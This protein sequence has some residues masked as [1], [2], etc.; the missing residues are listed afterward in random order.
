MGLKP[1]LL[2]VNIT[3]SLHSGSP[4]D[5]DVK[6]PLATEVFNLARFHIPH[7]K[8][9][10]ETEKE[11]LSNLNMG[12]EVTQLCLD[13][14][15]YQ[16]EVS[17][18]ERAKQDK[19][20]AAV[21]PESYHESNEETSSEEK[22]RVNYKCENSSFKNSSSNTSSIDRTTYLDSILEKLTP[23][24]VRTL[25]RSEDELALAMHFSRIF[26]TQDTHRYLK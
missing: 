16:K 21:I 18:G 17:K 20:V 11:V 5:L 19:F 26:P 12:D 22:N 14:K 24:D 10:A 3:P 25:I 7:E 13:P 15:L 2:E 1:W 9:T 4:L 23:D 6:S 8:M